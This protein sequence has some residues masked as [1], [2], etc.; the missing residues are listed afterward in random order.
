MR[1]RGVPNPVLSFSLNAPS[2]THFRPL[3]SQRLITRNRILVSDPTCRN[4]CERPGP[5]RLI[6][7]SSPA[8]YLPSYTSLTG[9]EPA[10]NTAL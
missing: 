1:V 3:L 2:L 4:V 8:H 9:G 5:R 7:S 6:S 10:K